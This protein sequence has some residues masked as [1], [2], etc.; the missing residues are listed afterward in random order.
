MIEDEIPGEHLIKNE[1]LDDIIDDLLSIDEGS[2]SRRREK[3]INMLNKRAGMD[4][5]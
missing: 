4:E 1:I 3:L 5:I 2:E